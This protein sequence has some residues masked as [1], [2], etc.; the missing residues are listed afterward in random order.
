L[1][2]RLPEFLNE[3]PHI[4]L[5]LDLSDKLSTLATDGFDLAVR[6]VARPPD[7]YVAWELARTRPL[8]VASTAYLTQQG[9]PS[10]PTDLAEHR[11]LYYPRPQGR[12]TWTFERNGSPDEDAHRVTVPVH[13]TFA[14]NNSEVLRDVA[15]AGL[16][17]AVVPDF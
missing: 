3:Y 8:L 2:P 10:C 13:G 5:E 9:T 17:V 12:L 7:T 15:I 4:R 11:C 16:G 1:V 6:H 14:A